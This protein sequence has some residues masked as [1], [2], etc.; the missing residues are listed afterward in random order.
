MRRL[1]NIINTL[2][3]LVIRI[4][5]AYIESTKS[6]LSVSRRDY[7]V[8]LVQCMILQVMQFFALSV[9]GCQSDDVML[10]IRAHSPLRRSTIRH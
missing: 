10:L 7:G 8:I 2:G 5:I 3:Q 6:Y 9:M 4:P 1:F